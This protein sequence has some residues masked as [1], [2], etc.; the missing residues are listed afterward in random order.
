MNPIRLIVLGVA[1][2]AGMACVALLARG[3]AASKPHVTPIAVAA[4]AAP[5][6]RVLVAKRDLPVGEHIAEADM[7]WHVWPAD[8]VNP[9]YITDGPARTAP[10]TGL[11]G[12]AGQV[13]DAAKSAMADPAQGAGAALIGSI[14]KER[15]LA[16]EPFSTLKIVHPGSAGAMAVTLDPGM[17]AMALPLS[18]ESAAGGFILPGDHVDVVLSRQSDS[19]GGAANIQVGQPVIKVYSADIVLK[20][21]RVLAIDQNTGPQ[22]GDAVVGA[23]ATVEVTPEQAR[24]LVIAKAAGQL[25]FILRSYAD[26][27]GPPTQGQDPQGGQTAGETVHIYRPSGA[28]TVMVNR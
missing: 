5:T 4:P 13:A 6:V 12:T 11:A 14:V 24:T 18:A 25:T 16:G 1:L 10:V 15:I 22:K 3:M 28:A 20:N 26:A 23:T 9:T 8:N 2:V 21:V 17:R 7:S 19:N 27:G